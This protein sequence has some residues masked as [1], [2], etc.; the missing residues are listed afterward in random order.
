MLIPCDTVIRRAL[1]MGLSEERP[2]DGVNIPEVFEPY[3]GL[4]PGFASFT[5]EFDGSDYR[6]WVKRSNGDPV[7][8]PL[9]LVVQDGMTAG[10]RGSD[11]AAAHQLP[12]YSA[13]TREIQLQG[14]LFARDRPLEG[15]VCAPGIA[16]GWSNDALYELCSS[17]QDAFSIEPATFARWCACFGQS[18]PT[19]ARLKLLRVLGFSKVRLC[20]DVSHSVQDTDDPVGE[21]DRI[22]SLLMEIR[23]LGYRSLALDL[24]V[25][26]PLKGAGIEKIS[27]LLEKTSVECVRFINEGGQEISAN[28]NPLSVL[29]S[30]ILQDLGYRHVG[31]DWYVTE[32]EPSLGSDSPLYWSPLGYTNIEGLDVIGVGPGAVAA[33]DDAYSRNAL[34]RESYQRMVE[35]GVIPTECG[36]E[37]ESDDLLRRTIMSGILVN[38]HFDIEMLENRWG[39]IFSRYFKPEMALLRTL[40]AQG[41]LKLTEHEIHT[42]DRGRESLY[43]L[44]KVFD[45]QD[46]IARVPPLRAALEKGET[47]SS[48]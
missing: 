23:A 6:E 38:E 5:R 39:I 47:V 26:E 37:L 41:K 18:R 20:L 30:G 3:C 48:R 8:A 29:R 22:E 45:N 21:I 42:L 16:V 36:V 17:I 25:G 7:P 13:V 14:T 11:P 44:C 12:W 1:N 35:Q 24:V 15:V 34:E 9:M 43:S 10:H 2:D 19:T 27:R 40:E 4:Y 31:L 32:A 33:L 28:D 46:S